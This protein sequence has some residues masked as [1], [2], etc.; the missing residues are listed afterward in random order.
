MVHGGRTMSYYICITTAGANKSG[1]R[2]G[3]GQLVTVGSKELKPQPEGFGDFLEVVDGPISSMKK[4]SEK[5]NTNKKLEKLYQ[6]WRKN[7]KN[8]KLAKELDKAREIKC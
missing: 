1:L 2:T 5:M 3:K 8:E 4:C 6:K 7:T